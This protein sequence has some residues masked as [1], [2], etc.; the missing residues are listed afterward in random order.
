MDMNSQVYELSAFSV[1]VLFFFILWVVFV[2]IKVIKFVVSSVKDVFSGGNSDDAKI[3]SMDA[4]NQI[5]SQGFED[6]SPSSIRSAKIKNLQG[7]DE[8]PSSGNDIK[9]GSNMKC[10]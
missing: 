8:V 6:K 10:D 7:V 5:V 4:A 9:I 1:A 3:R 2:S